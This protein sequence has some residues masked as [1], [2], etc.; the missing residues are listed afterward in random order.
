MA[1]SGAQRAGADDHGV[2]A[3][4]Q[5]AHQETVGGIFAAEDRTGRRLRPEGDN[6][7]HRC[8]EVRIQRGRGKAK[9]AIQMVQVNRQLVRRQA[10]CLVQDLE[11]LERHQ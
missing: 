6:T 4:A 9:A 3:S 10:V 11:G 1:G 2:G 8:N 5:E 7:V